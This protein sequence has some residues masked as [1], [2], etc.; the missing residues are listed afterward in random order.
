MISWKGRFCAPISTLSHINILPPHFCSTWTQWSVPGT[1]FP[2][3]APYFTRIFS[4]L[5]PNAKNH[6]V[7]LISCI[8]AHCTRNAKKVRFG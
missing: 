2:I 6:P 4:S 8:Y 3:G 1:G 7:D 5:V